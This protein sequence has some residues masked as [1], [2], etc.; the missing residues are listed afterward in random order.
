AYD[1]YALRAFR[2]NSVDYL[3]KPIDENELSRA[4]EK[5]K[6]ERPATNRIDID[7]AQI[8]KLLEN[9]FGKSYKSRIS[10]KIG[11]NVRVI[12]I[13]EVECFYSENKGTYL[14]T[15]DNRDYPV[16]VTLDALEADLDPAEFFRV[17][18]KFIVPLRSSREIA[19]YSNS[20]LKL[21][22]PTYKGDEVI[23]SRERVQDFR[24]WIG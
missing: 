10:V 17:S 18:R 20:R 13:A 8:R 15:F 4:V 12:P 7:V 3:L 11:T 16:D 2:L 14:H 5:Y 19:V 6:E 1:E 9:P 21:N 22:L 24:A 23:V